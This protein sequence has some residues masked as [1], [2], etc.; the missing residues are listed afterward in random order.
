M[1]I[2]LERKRKIWRIG[3]SDQWQRLSVMAVG[4][5][6]GCEWKRR[7]KGREG[8]QGAMIQCDWVQDKIFATSL[9]SQ[10]I[11]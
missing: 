3:G 7:K 4:I 8:G 10:P 5:E 2:V 9:P 6:N 11:Q 1:V